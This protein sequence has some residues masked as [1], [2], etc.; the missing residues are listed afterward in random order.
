MMTMRGGETH[1]VSFRLALLVR[2]QSARDRG[3]A[4][5]RNRTVK[6]ILAGLASAAIVLGVAWFAVDWLRDRQAARET[7]AHVQEM[8]AMLDLT[9]TP[10]FHRRLDRVRTFIND[11]SVHKMDAAFWA[12]RGNAAAFAAGVIAHAKRAL[13]TWNAARAP[14]SWG[15]SSVL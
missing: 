5:I 8:L 3:M 15:S 14:F 12:N 7:D 13:S 10:D 11:H 6:I 1:T 9:A 2:F 4:L